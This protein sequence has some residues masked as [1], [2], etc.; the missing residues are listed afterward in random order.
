MTDHREVICGMMG[1]I[2][3]QP[4][5]PASGLEG[6]HIHGDWKRQGDPVV[7]E[8]RQGALRHQVPDGAGGRKCRGGV[9]PTGICTRGHIYPLP[10]RCKIQSV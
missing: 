8:E 9:R 4:V 5:L 6:L 3:W 2:H 7:C 10:E 1:D